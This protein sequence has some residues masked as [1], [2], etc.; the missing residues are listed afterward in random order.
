MTH[1]ASTNGAQPPRSKPWNR[2]ATTARQIRRDLQDTYGTELPDDDA[3]RDNAE[4]ML[5]YLAHLPHGALKMKN[6]LELWCPWMPPPERKF[7]L[8]DATLSPTPRYTAD[9]LAARLG[10][11]YARRQK[12]HHTVIGAVDADKAE[13]TRRRKQRERERSRLRKERERREAGRRTR[14]QYLAEAALKRELWEL[15]GVSRATWYRWQANGKNVTPNVRQVGTAATLGI[16]AGTTCR[17]S[18]AER[19]AAAKNNGHHRPGQR[20]V[21]AKKARVAER[22]RALTRRS[23]RAVKVHH[24]T[25]IGLG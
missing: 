15:A 8:Q 5:H 16:A 3:G 20:R 14:Q 7:M 9:Q 11:T 24:F 2:C 1:T 17:I 10:T 21:A 4:L 6:F 18:S 12:L 22:H 23:R 25:A 13:R 19:T